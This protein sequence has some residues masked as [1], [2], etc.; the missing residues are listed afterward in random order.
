[1]GFLGMKIAHFGQPC[2]LAC[3]LWPKDVLI[4]ISK[5][6]VAVFRRSRRGHQISLQVIVSH[7]V[8]AGI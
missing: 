8:I 6:M 3:L 1:M 4:I 7:P 5:Y 2:L